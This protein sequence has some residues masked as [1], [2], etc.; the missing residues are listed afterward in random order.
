M[1]ILQSPF[2]LG[3]A[4]RRWYHL[5][6]GDPNSWDPYFKALKTQLEER[7]VIPDHVW[8]TEEEKKVAKQIESLLKDVCWGE[9][10]TFLP[11]DEF[12]PKYP[13]IQI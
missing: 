11:K 9:N 6:L 5:F 8:V 1:K 13:K 10:F 2:K 3:T 12:H 4:K 7:G